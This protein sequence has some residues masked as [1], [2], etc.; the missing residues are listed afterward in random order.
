MH[1]GHR[2]TTPKAL[3]VFDLDNPDWPSRFDAHRYQTALQRLAKKPE[4]ARAAFVH[5]ATPSLRHRR[6]N[7]ESA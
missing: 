7:P 5:S 6:P 1:E 2:S 4:P 3:A